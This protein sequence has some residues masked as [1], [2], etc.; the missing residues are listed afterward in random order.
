MLYP[1][2]DS[3]IG[4]LLGTAVGDAIGLPCEGLSK[5]RQDLLYPTLDGHHFLFGRGMISDDTEHTCMVA[6]ALIISAGDVQTF[7]KDLAL[8]L[9]FW[10]LGLPAGI[11]YA[12]L[13]SILRLWLGFQPEHSGIFSAGNGPAMRSAIIGV[14]YGNDSE[15]LRELVRSSTR[16]THT[17]VKAEFGALAVAVASHLS[18]RQSIISPKKYYSNPKSFVKTHT[19]Q[20][21]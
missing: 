5:R 7:K 3:I 19:H 2:S 21:A 1:T 10:L 15:K 20:Y 16:L 4:C 6:Q 9:R 12:T 18:S 11:G 8:R 14:S 13:R 17:D